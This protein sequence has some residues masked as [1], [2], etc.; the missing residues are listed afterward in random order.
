MIAAEAA[1]A[2]HRQHAHASAHEVGD[3]HVPPRAVDVM[4]LRG[5]R[6]RVMVPLVR[7]DDL[8]G[9]LVVNR[10]QPG[11]FAPRKVEL[12]RVFADQAS[13]EIERQGLTRYRPA[14]ATAIM[15][16]I[17]LAAGKR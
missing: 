3:E 6:S 9:I 4:R 13:A 14:T 16:N 10:Q 2:A 17:V 7:D 1:V 12:L 15:R 5:V 8:I 11:P